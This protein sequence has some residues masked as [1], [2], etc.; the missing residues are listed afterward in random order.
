[1]GQVL[2]RGA[3][4]TEVVRR[5]IRHSQENL[6]TLVAAMESTRDG[7]LSARLGCQA[8]GT[9]NQTSGTTGSPSAPHLRLH[10]NQCWPRVR[11]TADIS[12]W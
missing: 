3:T 5:A 11:L 7:S 10:A 2:H 9:D 4:T 1:M 8:L 6:R 12:R